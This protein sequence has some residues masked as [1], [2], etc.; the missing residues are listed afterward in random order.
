[1]LKRNRGFT[2]VELLVVIGIIAILIAMLMPALNKARQQAM[3]TACL[4][5][6]RQIVIAW[7]A[8]AA[9]NHGYNVQSWHS[10][11]GMAGGWGANWPVH[12]KPFLGNTSKVLTCPTAPVPDYDVAGGYRYGNAT[13]GW[14]V[15]P[16]TTA[17]GDF[18]LDENGSYAM[19]N[20]LENVG[21][22]F[23]ADAVNVM[24][25]ITD[26]GSGA[27]VPVVGDGTWLDAGWPRDTDPPPPSRI[28]PMSGGV[29]FM[30]RY[31]LAR[32][33][34]AI[35]IAFLDGSVR[36]VMP[37]SLWSLRWHK[38]FRVREAP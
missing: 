32:H 24:P 19:N 14:F 10:T 33:S 16:Y 11:G 15:T 21:R 36:R 9:E 4:S 27:D 20:W 3:T 25:K 31:F 26:G 12:I 37:E 7:H 22:W 17:M 8:Y 38:S 13:N 18:T 23:G 34:G 30:R 29:D 1:M 5:N 28:N 35:N 6:Q 2:L